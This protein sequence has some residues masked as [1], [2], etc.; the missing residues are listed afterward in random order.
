MTKSKLPTDSDPPS[1]Y[2][3][4]SLDGETRE[5]TR[6]R[7]TFIGP[8]RVEVKIGDGGMGVVYKAIDP[9]LNRPV[10]LKVLKEKLAYDRRYVERL[11]REARLLA[12]VSHPAVVQ[13]FAF[14]D[15]SGSDKLL[16]YLVMEYV[17]GESL[18]SLLERERR[19]EFRR[20]LDFLRQAAEGLEAA[21][22]KG[23]I[24][25][26]VK[27]SNLLISSEGRV[28]IVD[29]G[30]A[31]EVNAPKSGGPLTEDGVILG[32]PQYI[33]PEQGSGDSLDHRCDIYSLGATFFHAITGEVIFDGKSP[34]AIIYSHLHR[35]PRL[36]HQINKDLPNEASQLIGKMVAK[37]PGD[38]YESYVELIE[39]IDRLLDG[40]SLQRA[41]S[42]SARRTYRP[43]RPKRSARARVLQWVLASA[44]AVVLTALGAVFAVAF[45]G[46]PN[47]PR[48]ILEKANLLTRDSEAGTEV[49]RLPFRALLGEEGPGQWLERVF[50]MTPDSAQNL[51]RLVPRG[52]SLNNYRAPLVYRYEVRG[53]REIKIQGLSLNTPGTFGVKIVHARGGEAVRS[54]RFAF[55]SD[56]EATVPIEAIRSGDSQPLTPDPG[57]LS[58]LRGERDVV[59][60]LAT[61]GGKTNV[62]VEVRR[63][64]TSDILATLEC[65]VEGEDWTNG[66][67]VLQLESCVSPAN[68]TTLRTL[69]LA[70]DHLTGPE[71]R[72]E[73][74]PA[75]EI[76][77]AGKH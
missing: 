67:V 14:E 72:N 59:I 57:S 35:A 6:A 42:R 16:P 48:D 24:H 63:R 58:P 7:D 56:K 50:S 38:R 27:P 4:G 29:F 47:T 13:I 33:S 31:K 53:L 51:P 39:D 28:K 3:D 32:T 22:Q 21:Y 11:D 5:M 64:K 69:V 49:L 61:A 77:R 34:A 71:V 36:P 18:E 9:R 37:S 25:R 43:A 10:A 46:D 23:I 55:L 1:T 52:L 73:T 76:S 40:K 60:R 45:Q 20:A 41:T 26:D 54:L 68:K 74:A 17:D 19:L 66:V 8:Y 2:L 70:A 44:A 75:T 65:S 30:L 62:I 15:G 12:T